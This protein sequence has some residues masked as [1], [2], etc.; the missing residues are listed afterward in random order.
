MA[1][2]LDS[3]KHF[4]L[5][6]LYLNH[7]EDFRGIVGVHSVKQEAVSREQRSFL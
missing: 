1:K 6:D 7:C 3:A 4:F 2:T 5:E